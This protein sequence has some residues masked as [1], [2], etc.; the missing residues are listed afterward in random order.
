MGLST[1][2]ISYQESRVMSNII[3]IHNICHYIMY[4]HDVISHNTKSWKTEM[5]QNQNSACKQVTV[6]HHQ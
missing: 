6:S 4:I 3:H 5:F 1:S 2:N